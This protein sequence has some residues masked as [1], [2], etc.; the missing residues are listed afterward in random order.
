MRLLTCSC[1]I[2]VMQRRVTPPCLTLPVTRQV[3]CFQEWGVMRC[4]LQVEPTTAGSHTVTIQAVVS[5]LI[6]AVLVV[7]AV[8]PDVVAIVA[9]IPNSQSSLWQVTMRVQT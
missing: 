1:S 4:C 8:I 9:R 3:T 5:L 2:L 6:K 7:L